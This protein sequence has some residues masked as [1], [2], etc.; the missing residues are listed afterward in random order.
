MTDWVS[1]VLLNGSWEWPEA[2]RMRTITTLSV[3]AVV[4]AL[5]L[6]LDRTLGGDLT[7]EPIREIILT[8]T[9]LVVTFSIL[10]QGLTVGPLIGRLGSTPSP[11]TGGQ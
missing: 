3:L 6:S 7:D 5:A 11:E 1:S 9:Y 10:V 2:V 8:S 4:V